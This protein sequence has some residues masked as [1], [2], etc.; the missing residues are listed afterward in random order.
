MIIMRFNTINDIIMS[1]LSSIGTR[2]AYPVLF[3][4]SK[5]NYSDVTK[6]KISRLHTNTKLHTKTGNNGQ[7]LRQ[8]RNHTG[9]LVLDKFAKLFSAMAFIHINMSMLAHLSQAAFTCNVVL[10]SCDIY[11]HS[12]LS[13]DKHGKSQWV[14]EHQQRTHSILEMEIEPKPN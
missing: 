5:K 2:R 12:A 1:R 9:I 10:S 6:T 8:K 4:I 11:R 3:T 7:M 13:S 14:S